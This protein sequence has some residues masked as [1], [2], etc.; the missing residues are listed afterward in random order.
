M[1]DDI[2]VYSV[3]AMT[4]LGF[5]FVG[6]V[7]YK[8]GANSLYA[9]PR[10]PIAEAVRILIMAGTLVVSLGVLTF[11]GWWLHLVPWCI[12][13][14]LGYVWIRGAYLLFHRRKSHTLTAEI[15][16]AMRSGRAAEPSPLRG[17]GSGEW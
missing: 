2:A 9:P 1:L 7:I 8:R 10:S 6:I 14:Y 15:L 13:L 17:L 4:V 16:P 12:F 3:G 5:P 11:G